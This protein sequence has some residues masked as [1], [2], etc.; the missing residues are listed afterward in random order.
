[1]ETALSLTPLLVVEWVR[2][3]TGLRL[4]TEK[5]GATENRWILVQITEDYTGLL[6]EGGHSMLWPSA[7][8]L[9]PPGH[10]A[11]PSEVQP[12]QVNNP[13]LS[14]HSQDLPPDVVLD[15][16]EPVSEKAPQALALHVPPA[17]ATKTLGAGPKPLPPGC[18]CEATPA[19]TP[20]EW[21][22]KSS[23]R[24]QPDGRGHCH[25]AYLHI[26]S[27]SCETSNRDYNNRVEDIWRW[28]WHHLKHLRRHH[29][30]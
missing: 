18:G 27:T 26:R 7:S 30:L 25:S 12:A 3:A 8:S 10:Q 24:P 11:D 17:Q 6:T 9:E 19:C 20:D 23:S 13:A 28:D 16:Q 5:H 29:Q 2:Q 22:T 14:E 15:L 1:M 4:G 21:P